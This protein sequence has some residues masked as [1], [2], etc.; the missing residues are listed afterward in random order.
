MTLV[1]VV[2]ME[3]FF[4]RLTGL[5]G[6]STIDSGKFYLLTPC[7]S[8]HTFFMKLSL[9]VVFVDETDQILAL[10]RNIG[11]NKM[12]YHRGAK[13]VLEGRVGLIDEYHLKIGEQIRVV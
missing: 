5:M 11:K 1:E 8:I 2:K 6:R 13:A 10:H 3:T 7:S 12:L 9:D 4:T